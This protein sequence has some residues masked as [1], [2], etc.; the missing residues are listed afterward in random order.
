[1][2][3]PVQRFDIPTKPSLI[4][5][6]RAFRSYYPKHDVVDGGF[7]LT[8]RHHGSTEARAASQEGRQ[9]RAK[10]RVIWQNSVHSERF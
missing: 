6:F 8:D 1:M 10:S 7:W 5:G 4:E 2:A 3:D 9:G